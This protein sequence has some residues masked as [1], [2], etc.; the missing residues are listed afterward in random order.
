MPSPGTTQPLLGENVNLSFT[1][2]NTDPTDVGYSPY[3]VV[4]VDTSGV[5]GATTA[6]LDGLTAPT[7]TGAGLNL[8]PVGSPVTL[9]AGQTTF[10]NPF[11]GLTESVPAGFGKNDT[12]YVYQLPFGSF[13][14]NQ[15]TAVTIT[16]GVS[17]LADVN[18][19]L[20]LS[21]VGGYRSSQPNSI[22][23]VTPPP[24]VATNITPQLYR[25]KKV[26]QGPEDET[27][28]GPNFVRRYRLELDVADGQ[29]LTNLR[30]IDDLPPSH[31]IVGANTTVVAGQ[32]NMAA[33]R[34]LS[35]GVQG[36]NI[37][38]SSNLT[39]TAVSSAPDGTLN[40]NFG[41]HLG[42]AGVDA[43]FEYNFYVPR[44]QANPPGGA[45][46]PQGVDK[47]L[48]TNTV[49]STANWTPTDTRDPA[50]AVTP[51]ISG[52][53]F[54]HVLEQQS[55][56]VQKGV[57]LFDLTTGTVLNGQAVQPG[58]TL[59]RYT[60]DF[61]VSDY[62]A[63]QNITLEDLLS[64][65][66]R[67]YLANLPAGLGGTAALPT[68]AVNNAF[69]ANAA[70]NVGTRTNTTGAFTANGVIEY[71]GRFTTGNTL[72]DPS[73]GVHGYAATGP[74]SGIFTNLGQTPDTNV[75][76]GGATYLK[77]DISAELRQRLGAN[78]GR[79]IGGE[80]NNDGTGPDN[81][82]FAGPRLGP[83]TGQIIFYALVSEEFSDAFP[84]GNPSVDQGDILQNSVPEIF[85]EQ[86]TAATINAVTPTRNP[87][88]AISTDDSG[89]SFSVPYGVSEKQVYAIN[90]QTVPAA[91]PTD[92]PLEIQ[93]GDRVTFKLTYTL[94][95][96]SFEQLSLVDIPPLP[97]MPVGAQE[98]YRFESSGATFNPY[99]VSIAP[100]DTFFSTIN[101][102]ATPVQAATIAALG[103]GTYSPTG[104]ASG[105]GAFT[106]APT[107]IDG[108][109]LVNGDR[110][111]VKNQ[112]DSRQNGVYVVLNA[113]TGAW[114]RA[115]DFDAVTEVQN[116]RIFQVQFGA[117]NT[118]NAFVPNNREF[119]SFN[120]GSA[121]LSGI[122][123]QSFVT[124]DPLQNEI[125]FNFGNLSDT[126]VRRSTTISLLLT[127]PMGTDPFVADLFLT[128]QL[129][130]LEASTNQGTTT[131]EDLRMIELVRP[132]V[133]IQ[134]GAVAGRNIGLTTSD[135]VFQFAPA[136]NPTGTVT[137][138]G[139]PLSPTN[140]IFS[141]GHASAI[142]G[143]NI[144]PSNISLDAS[145]AVRYAL[146]VNN[147]GAGDAYDVV[148]EDQIQ[149]GLVIPPTFNDLNLRVFRGDGSA[150]T[151]RT[152]VNGVVRAA[153]NGAFPPAMGVV[154]TT[155]SGGRFT[156]VDR[157]FSGIQLNLGD[158][159]LIKNQ[160]N[161][162]E[163]GIYSVT[164]VDLA[165]QK[166]VLTRSVDF[167]ESSEL[168]A[169]Y[170]VGVLGGANHDNTLYTFPATPGAVLNSTNVNW[171][172]GGDFDYFYQYNPN[173]T[174][175]FG[176]EQGGF[177]LFFRD[178]YTAGNV[179]GAAADFGSGALSSA[180]NNGLPITNGSNSL[181]VLYDTTVAP[182]SNTRPVHTGQT[183]VNTAFV[184]NFSNQ[185]GG[186]DF[187]DPT[188]VADSTDPSDTATVEILR[189]TLDKV[190][191]SS[192]VVNS[193][194]SNTQVV[195]G[196]IV[197]YTLT[198]TIPEG[199]TRNTVLLD[200]LDSGLAFV[201]VTSVT[202]SGSLTFTGGGLPTVGTNPANTTITNNGNNVSF[203]LGT[204]NN[205]NSDNTTAETITIV[206][207][208]VVLNVAGNQAGTQL[209][210]SV[211][212]TADRTNSP[213]TT[214]TS[215]NVNQTNPTQNVTVIEPRIVTAKQVSKDGTNFTVGTFDLDREDTL[216]YR[217]VLGNNTLPL[218]PSVRVATT[219]NIGTGYV[220]NIEGYSRQITGG[221][222]SIDG[223]TLQLQ[224]RVLVKNQSNAAQNG[225]YVYTAPGV[226]TSAPEADIAAEYVPN[227][228]LRVALGT[229]N[230]GRIFRQNNTVTTLSTDPIAYTEISPT[231]TDAVDAYDVTVF[232]PL[233]TSSRQAYV[234][235]SFTAL[236]NGT[237]DISSLFELVQPGGPNT[238][239]VLRT[240]DGSSFDLLVG[241]F[242]QITL[243]GTVSPSINP[244]ESLANSATVRWT[245]LNDAIPSPAAGLEPQAGVP[246]VQSIHNPNSTE[247]SGTPN[248]DGSGNVN[249]YASTG[250]VAPQAA[251]PILTKLVVG[252]SE[253]HTIQNRSLVKFGNNAAVDGN[254]T[255]TSGTGTVTPAPFFL[256]VDGNETFRG[257]YTFPTPVN[258]RG[259]TTLGVSLRADVG[260]TADNIVLTLSDVDG[261][262]ASYTF[263][264]DGASLPP[265]SLSFSTLFANLLAPTITSNGA[266]S[267]L[268]ITRIANVSI[269]GDG[270]TAVFRMDIRDITALRTLVA[271]GEIVRYRLIF[272][273][274]E[275]QL[276]DLMLRDLLPAGMQ[277]L[278]DGTA[279]V[280]FVTNGAGMTSS[281]LAGAGLLFAGD[282]DNINQI[283]LSVASGNGLILPDGAISTSF[284]INDDA[285]GNGTDVIFK[286]GNILNIENDFDSEYIVVEFNAQVLNVAT[287]QSGV[288]L[289]NQFEAFLNGSTTPLQLGSSSGGDIPGPSAVTDRNRIVVV[290]PQINNL[291][292]QIN[293][294][295]PTDAGDPIS[296]EIR[297]SNNVAHP[298]VAAPRVRASTTGNIAPVS[299]TAN[300]LI[301]PAT[302]GVLT[303]D[304]VA[305]R[306]QDRVLVRAQSTG[307]Q[308]G[309]Y[310]VTELN[311]QTGRAT[312][313]RASD[314]DASSE[315]VFGARVQ[316]LEGSNAGRIYGI[317]TTGTITPGSSNIAFEQLAANPEVRVATVTA[318]GGTFN[319]GTNTYT[320]ANRT[321]DGVTLNNGDRVLVKNQAAGEAQ[322]H[323]VFVVT[324]ASGSTVNLVRA[325]DFDQSAEFTVG[326]QISVLEGAVNA[327]RVFGMYS[328]VNT[329]NTDNIL[330]RTV[331]QVAAFNLVLTDPLPTDVLFQSITIFTPENPAGITLTASGSFTG[332][333]VTLPAVG[334]TGTITITL[335]RLD[336]EEDITGAVK[337]VRILVNGVV[338]DL[339]AGGQFLLNKTNLTYTGL[340]GG[341][342]LGNPTGSNILGAAG[343]TTGERTGQD[344][345]LPNDNTPPTFSPTLNN[346]SVG[347]VL[348]TP[349][350]TPSI[351]KRFQGGSLTEDDTSFSSTT[352]SNVAIGE[353]IVYDLRVTLPEGQINNLAIQDLL[354]PGLRL[355][356]T[357]NG[358]LGYELITAASL[359]N[360]QLTADFNGTLNL[361][362]T[363]TASGGTLGNDGVD[364]VLTF[365]NTTVNTALTTD[366]SFLIRVRVIA[367]NVGSN[368]RGTL[369]TNVATLSYTDP[370]TNTTATVFDTTNTDGDATPF[371]PTVIIVEPQLQ[372][373]KTVLGGDTT[374]DAGLPSAATFEL[375]IRHTGVSNGPAFDLQI[376][377]LIPTGLS[378]VAGSAIIFS[379]PAY[380]N[381]AIVNNGPSLSAT[382]D[383]LRVGDVI[384][385]RYEAFIVGPPNAN[386]PAPGGT[387]TN[388][389][390]TNY[391][392]APGNNP[393]ERDEAQISDTETLTVHT[394]TISGRIYSDR[395]N[396]GLFDGTDV[397]I[398]GQNIRVRLTGTDHLG[399]AVD[400]EITT[401]TG[402]YS[403]TGLRPG[404]YSVT[405]LDQPVGF[406]DGRDTPGT[407]SPGT[408][409]GGTGTAATDNRGTPSTPT[410]D[411]EA[412]NSITIGL[413]QNKDGIEYNF[414]EVQPAELGN[415]VWEDLNGN[416]R[417]DAGEPGISGISVQ[418]N[419]TDDT[420]A[421]V[422]ESTTTNGTGNYLFTNLR[423]GSYS[424]TFGNSNG[425]K[426]Y[427]RTVAN[428]AVANDTNDSDAN[429]TTGITGSYTLIAGQSD[430]TVDAGLY[431]PITLGNRVFFDIDADGKQD[432][433]EPGIANVDIQ[434]VWLG[435]DGVFGGGDDKTFTTQTDALGIWT[436]AGLPPGSFKVTA[437]PPLN[438]GYTVLTDSFDNGILSP[439]N[440][441]TPSTT[442]GVNRDDIDFGYR[443][444]AKLGDFVW[445]DRDADGVQDVGEPGLPGVTVRLTFLGS[446]GVLGGGDDA[447]FETITDATGK[448]QF[449]N[450]PA[451]KFQV[452]VL[453]NTLPD[454][455]VQTFD[456]NGGLDNLATRQL[457][458]G[459][460]ATDVDFG[461]V[462]KGSIGD[463]VWYD[464][465]GDGVQDLTA[466][467]TERGI[468]GVTVT[469]TWGGQDG[470]LSTTAD[471]LIYTTTT[472]ADGKYLFSGLFAGDFL[473]ATA[474]NYRVTV[475]QP[476]SFP[477]RTFDADG[478]GTANVSSLRLPA[479]TA[480][481]NQDFGYRGTASLGDFV[482]EDTNGNGKFDSG[483]LGV[484]GVTVELY[485]DANN[486]GQV[487]G[488]ELAAPIRSTVT[489]ANGKYAFPDLAAG[490]YRV[491]FVRPV[492]T[493]FTVPNSTVPG[494]NDTND[495]DASNLPASQGLTQV[496]ALANGGSDDTVDAG[497]VRLVN[498]GDTVW[499]DVNKNGVQNVG[500][501]GI[502]NVRINLAYA[503]PDGV[504]GTGDDNLTLAFTDTDSEGKYFF[505]LLFPGV[506]KVSVDTSTGD[507][508]T[509]GLTQQTYD[510]DGIV[511]TPNSDTKLV[512]SG[513]NDFAFDFGYVGTRKLGDRV[514]VDQND[515][516]IQDPNE[517]GISGAKVTAQ[518]A[519]ADGLFNTADDV[520]QTQI[521]GANGIYTFTDIPSGKYRVSVDPTT[522]PNG[523]TIP[524]YDLDDTPDST[525]DVTLNPEFD[526]DDVDF[527]YRGTLSL[528]DRVWFDHDGD[529]VQD[530]GEPGVVGAKVNLIWA[531]QDG[532]L[533][534]TADNLVISTITGANGIY[535]FTNLP[536]GKFKVSVD[537]STLPPN[538]TV[539]TYD[540]D[541]GTTAPDQI[542]TIDNLT[543]NRV[544]VDFGYKGTLSLGD[545]IWHDQDGDGLQDGGEQGFV[546]VTVTLV[547]AGQDNDFATTADNLV[548]TTTTGAN[549]LYGFSALPQGAY[550]VTVGAGLPTNIVATYDLDNG[551]TN[552][553]GEAVL[554]GAGKL[555]VSRT[556]VDFGYRGNV[557]IGNEVWFDIDGDGVFDGDEIGIG[558]VTV[559]VRYF[560][561]NG[562]EG[563]GDDMLFSAVTVDGTGFWQIANLPEGKYRA[564]VD[565]TTLPTGF[566]QQTYDL[567]LGT[568]GL[569]NTAVFTVT[570]TGRQD[571]DFGYRG[572]A[573]L[574]DLVWED[575]V[576]E[577]SATTVNNDPRSAN[578]KFDTGEKVLQGV[579]VSL[580]WAGRDGVFGN[581]DDFTRT[582]TTD[583]NGI[584]QFLNLPAGQFEVT[585]KAPTGYVF[586][587]QNAAADN[588]DSDADPVTGKTAPI[589]LLTGES[590]QTVDA[591]VFQPFLI[592]EAVPVCFFDTP[593]ISYTVTPVGVANPQEVDISFFKNDGS[594]EFVS[595]FTNPTFSGGKFTG[596]VLYPGAKLDGN[597][598]PIDW[599]GWDLVGGRWVQVNDGLRPN[600]RMSFGI[601]PNASLIVS[602]PDPSQFC[603]S[604]PTVSIG[605]LIFADLN[606]NGVFDPGA[607]ETG[608]DGVVVELWNP[609]ADGKIGGGDDTLVDADTIA[610]GIQGS[611]VT[612]NGGAYLFNRIISGQYYV[613]IPESN[614]QPG[615]ALVGLVSSYQFGSDSTTD[616]NADENG[617]DA[618]NPAAV[619]IN[620]SVFDAQ[621]TLQPTGEPQFG[622]GTF[623]ADISTNLTFDFGFVEPVTV[624][625]YAFIDS[626]G[627][628]VQDAGDLPLA[629]VVVELIDINGNVLQTATTG[630]DG[631][632]SFETAPGAYSIR[633]TPPSGYRATVAN[634]GANDAN[635]S[636]IDVNTLTTAQF[637]LLA[638]T[639]DLTRDAGFYIPISLGDRVWYD[640]NND[641]LQNNGEPGIP[642]AKVT[643]TWLGVDGVLGGGDD[644][645]YNP[646][647]TD[648]NGNWTL[649]SLPPGNF[650]VQVT[651]LPEGV[652]PTYDLDGVGTPSVTGVTTTSGVDRTDVDF[653][654][655][656][657]GSLGD[658]IFLD[659]NKNGVYD[660]GEGLNNVTVTVAGDLNGDGIVG[661]GETLTTTTGSDGFYQFT[662]L[663]VTAAGVDY[664]VTVNKA[665]LPQ[666]FNGS[667]VINSVD[668]DTASPGDSTSKVTLTAAVPN[669][670]DQ[671]FGYIADGALG[672]TIFVDVNNN[673]AYDA[674]EGVSGVTV[675][676]TADFDLDGTPTT[677]T[678]VTGAD[679]KYLFET[680][681]V[682]DKNG[683]FLPYTVN[684][685]TNTLPA[686]LTN[687]VDPDG[688]NNSKSVT[689]LG[690]GVPTPEVELAQ[691]FGYRGPG[692]I[693]DRIFVDLNGD[694]VFTPGEGLFGVT[695]RLTAD[696]TGDGIPE[697][698]TTTTGADGAYLFSGLPIFR[699]DGTT[700]I[701][702]TVEVLTNT[703]PTGLT[704]SVDPDGG[705]NSTSQLT[706]VANA[707]NL[708]QDFGYVGTAKLGD[709]VWLDS[710]GDGAQG[711]LNLEPGLPGSKLTLTWAGADGQ[712]GTID[713]AFTVL[714]TDQFGNY[715]FE[716]LALGN[717]SV[718]VDPAS[719]PGNLTP[720]Y[721][722]DGVGTANVATRALIL[723]EVAT[724]VDFGYVGNASLGDRVWIDQNRD[725]IQDPTEPGVPGAIVEVRWAGVDGIIDTSDDVLYSTTTGPNGAY[726][727]PGLPVFGADDVYRVSVTGL[728]IV[729]LIPVYDLD[730]GIATPDQTTLATVASS[731]ALQNRR[732]VDFGYDGEGVL[733]G[734]VYRDDNNNGVQDPGEPGIAGVTLT[735]FGVDPFGNPILN[736]VTGQPY[737]TT[738]DANG[739]YGFQTAIPGVYRIVETQ[740]GAY[741]DG[742]DSAGNLGGN[743]GN[744]VI[745][746]INVPAN[747]T[748]V[749]YNFGEIGTF[750]S[751]TVFYDAARDG[752]F[753][754][755][756][757]GLGGVI[758]ELR[759]ASNNLV[760]T[761]T[762]AADGTYRFDNLPAG[763]Y[764]ITEIQPQGYGSST[765]NTLN[766]TVPLAGLTN[767]NFGETLSTI[768]GNVFH[769]AN[770]D[771]I[772]NA[773]EVGIA[774]VVVTLT[775]TDL[776]GNPVNRTTFT[777]ANGNYRFVELLAS[778]DAG[779]TISEFLPTGYLDGKDQVGSFGGNVG[780]TGPV[781]TI[782]AIPTPSGSDGFN[783][784][785]GEIASPLRTVSGTVF[786]DVA[787]NGILE[788]GDQG[789]SG[790]LVTLYD[791]KNN[792]VGTT[793]TDANG[794]YAFT[795]LPPGKYTIVESQPNAYGSSS[796]NLLAVDLTAGN[797]T[798]QNF[799]ETT[800]D[801]AGTVYFD[802]NQDGQL[803]AGETGI[804]GVTVTLTGTDVNGNP[805]TQST[806]TDAN[807]NYRFTGLLA[808]NYTVTETQ[809]AIYADG[810]E[811]LGSLGGITDANDVIRAIPLGAGISATAYNF[812]EIG[813]PVSGTVFYDVNRNGE[814]DGGETPIGGV[815]IQL[816][817]SNGQVVATT[818]T[819]GFGNYQFSNVPP[820]QYTI[821]EIQPAGYGDPLV[822]SFAPNSRPITVANTPITGQNFG[823]TLSTI[824]GYVY[825]D[826]N[827]NNVRD[828][829]EPGIGGVVM[830]LDSAGNDGVFGTSDDVLEVAFTTTGTNG[831]YSFTKLPQ[832]VYRVVEV[833]QPGLY[834]DGAETAGAAGGDISTNDQISAI[835]L[836]AG[837]DQPDYNFGE[838]LVTVQGTG[839]ITGT[840]YLDT[841]N[842]GVQDPGE[843]GL[844]G[845]EVSVTNGQSTFVTLTDANGNYSFTNLIP[846]DYTVTETQP[847]KYLTGLENSG[848]TSSA[849]VPANGQA[850]VNFGELPGTITGVVYFDADQSG[851]LTA[852]DKVLPG[853]LVSLV[854][855]EGFPV[856]DRLTGKPL[857]AVTGADG[858]YTFTGLAAGTYRVLETQP[859]QYNQGATNPGDFGSLFDVDA[860]TVELPAGGLS[861][862]NNFGEIGAS[863]SGVV[864]FDANA[865]GDRQP[866]E[867]NVLAGVTITLLDGQ[868]NPIATTTTAADGSY[869]FEN[870]P[871]G[872]YFVVQTQPSTH[873]SSPSGLFAPNLRPVTL[874]T[875]DVVNQNFAETLGSI[876][877]VVYND[878]NNNGIQ[879]VGEP[880]IA[881]VLLT[882]TGT[883][884]NGN[885][886]SVTTTTDANGKYLFSELLTG[887][888]SVTETQPAQYNDGLD[889]IGSI[890][891]VVANDLQSQIQLGAGIQATGYNFGEIGADISGKVY[892]D[893]N[894][895]GTIDGR[896]IAFAGVTIQLLDANGKLIATTKTAA[897]GTYLFEHLPA[898]KYTIV[899]LQ[900]NGYGS[901]TPNTLPVTLPLTGLTNQN[902]G[903]TLS[904][905]GGV[906]FLDDNNNGVRD[907]NEIG[908]PN[909]TI[910]LTGTDVNNL[911]IDRTVLTGPDG[912]YRF[913]DLVQGSYTLTETQPV[914][915]GDGQDI[916]G[917]FGGT[918][919]NDVI[920]K[921]P[922][923]AGKI[924]VGYDFGEL[925]GEVRGTV[926]VDADRD[927]V[928]DPGE[929]R[930]PGEIVSLVDS[931]GNVYATTT[932]DANGN[933]AFIGIPP[934]NYRV[935]QTQPNGY[936]SS[937]SNDVPVS[938]PPS[939][940]PVIV[941]FGET[942]GSLSGYVYRDFA[943][944]GLRQPDQGETGIG[945]VRITLTGTDVR[946][947]LINREIFTDSAGRYDFTGLLQG[948][949]VISESKPNGFFYDGLDTIGSQGGST[950]NDR[951]ELFLGAGVDGIENNFGENP[952]ADPFGYV[953]TD[954]NRNGVRDPGEPGIAGVPIRIEG[955]AFAGTPLARPLQDSDLPGGSRT[956]FTNAAGRYEYPIIPPGVYTIIQVLQPV[957]YL[958]GVEENADPNEP[959]T[960]IVGNDRFD[961]IVLDPFPIRGPFNFGELL[962]QN[963]NE[964]G[965]QSFLAST[966]S[967]MTPGTSV[968]PVFPS[969]PSFQVTTGTP[970]Q[971][972][973]VVT[974]SGTGGS[975]VVR[976]FDFATG[977][978]MLRFE[979]FESTFTGGVRTAT[980][981]INQDGIA[982][983]IVVPGFGGGPIVR[984]F[985]GVDG[986]VIREFFAYDPNFRDGL[987][988]A[989]GDVTGDGVVDIVTSPGQG[990]GPHIQVW[991]GVTGQSVRSFFAY[992]SSFRGGVHVAV[993]DTDGDGFADIITGAGFGGG[994]HVRVFSGRTGDELQSFM[995]Y[996][997]NV[998]GGA[999]VAAGDV[1000]GDGRAEIITGAGVG[1001]GPNVKVFR[1002]SDLMVLS[1003][1004][1005]A[1006]DP[1007]FFGGVRVST[1008]DIDGD[1009]RA[1010]IVSGTGDGSTL[1011]TIR[1012]LLD[1013]TDLETFAPFDLSESGGVFVG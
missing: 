730:S 776:L 448:Y 453:T 898:G 677:I 841:N 956:I 949:Y 908:V 149:P 382:A 476:A 104:G 868:G 364:F 106:G 25:L 20:N 519:G 918:L 307:T 703:I 684:V 926:Y 477:I 578:G 844:I 745:D 622:P 428:S 998:R 600:I 109:A 747:A 181:L 940:I 610:P 301:I 186:L 605:N 467:A 325:T 365:G 588:L 50:T 172:A 814:I 845:V 257:N 815:T 576:A 715:L 449:T 847:S 728:P 178:S 737:T 278:N 862:N 527:G 983:I 656:G 651:N 43:V 336:A 349:L 224:D 160:A 984:V 829:G 69:L 503:G 362:P 648:A 39:G 542:V 917:S 119:L 1010:E 692:S 931:Q 22:V 197:T 273:A 714:V 505:N 351:D 56:A 733:G 317:R 679:G 817:D 863:I 81:D 545:R 40:Y 133:S 184:R 91:G 209:N 837:V 322:N 955:I 534:T 825:V 138:S 563:D 971:P 121:T 497:I 722:L 374:R 1008:Q 5:D 139:N 332:G 256:R 681:P 321:I 482:W 954:L 479:N 957:G 897:D 655:R 218:D 788:L 521:T 713:D 210:N 318:V 634:V 250:S 154:Y 233:P 171:V 32:P 529:G 346:Y 390:T 772:R 540:L 756:D 24:A 502:A 894:R 499:Y 198:L 175:Q 644:I 580:R 809:P 979:A 370:N 44:D 880:G 219:A 227:Q 120:S 787:K 466:S 590:N 95:I 491:R 547:Y 35:P 548:L 589:T 997:P 272:Q 514:W 116:T 80:I 424:V 10:V 326:R 7:V 243:T 73:V 485:W 217:I 662:N 356:T 989:V 786:V 115:T 630:A 559:N 214:S 704:N 41:T 406:L 1:F 123:F 34:Y 49:S 876:A 490:N 348:V 793:T 377:D 225:I 943:I 440:P 379:A 843:V 16:T 159:V 799:G 911:P 432:S 839:A 1013:N 826:T 430:L 720:T 478:L 282:Q 226:F 530:S 769:D 107:T 936:S 767:Q 525:T 887:T 682:R 297:F 567:D 811:S 706:L 458:S 725:G 19:P 827:V 92:P 744:D 498:I 435:P 343:T 973:F 89:A 934:G 950:T 549:G 493:E 199:Q 641:G 858:S 417:F 462:G 442:S 230:G 231:Y 411:G 70:T 386:A 574:G 196:E 869:S 700:P 710:N 587:P 208:A 657:T 707:N 623:Q 948:N 240:R 388:T 439:T 487:D 99:S 946:G 469:L 671:D 74:T 599:P 153:S 866:T 658:R 79:L 766:V 229:A 702:Y 385:I 638:G 909:V 30:V 311:T 357:F 860:I 328:T 701:T 920:S 127:L 162:Q 308:N 637:T 420:G 855:V 611:V 964:V 452:E 380:S 418:I 183:I 285:Y 585:F 17:K 303:I 360:G 591:G 665:D 292:K 751:G 313:T 754:T 616:Q 445:H 494:A 789:L 279:R 323:G 170:R 666:R 136:T 327:G 980:G 100:D 859:N 760:A 239:Q 262:T 187:T 413:E 517:P 338:R 277:F 454:E 384:R 294:T 891:G 163:N 353:S 568:N 823:N 216:Y 624:G 633:F 93:A 508:D 736:P 663:R 101:A 723:G 61:Q 64:D 901:S 511:V 732:D 461:Y 177:R 468:P 415:L 450:L 718:T 244:A 252:S 933:Y 447:V 683:S 783:Y 779:Y 659:L 721:D 914:T 211:Q 263:A 560:G 838:V 631:K 254:F 650:K 996:D 90:S 951:H 215:Y 592:I 649:G 394:N 512:P 935:V 129:R 544:D 532:D 404:V 892:V 245:S 412:I 606:G 28:T 985:S 818:T 111:L 222:T 750:I 15:S 213:G 883:D 632:Y 603:I 148:V 928:L 617:I 269:G 298:T 986:T 165:T 474:P 427:D 944:N 191:T 821:V 425:S 237:T 554:A 164:S 204:I 912:S 393:D 743:T 994:P 31:Q 774:G 419:G 110:V 1009:G 595:T 853:V 194:N 437:T 1005:F 202:S 258:L 780:Q 781:D 828:V 619:G 824:S 865:D 795:A 923:P 1001:G 270:G 963:I 849:T 738:T 792:I 395:N 1000:D 988:V 173:V 290:E 108:R 907:A 584:Y 141:P 54:Q 748:G 137:R 899:E 52:S 905:I 947:N 85:G 463:T 712:L 53:T 259:Y 9:I 668:P 275:G 925:R 473:D 88:A 969:T 537:A 709:R 513:K 773:G 805:V 1004:Y 113:A 144:N 937:T 910:R 565:T 188:Y 654:Y 573:K 334:T 500:E 640:T 12:I 678:T 741:N 642:N 501:P 182:V 669:R 626:N 76:T 691:D 246:I 361:T 991:D 58:R 583:S 151:T 913:D 810:Q 643:V 822:G 922:V 71:Q 398:T 797:K 672:D 84:S 708:D 570:G 389:A 504:F 851:T 29:T 125:R 688:G 794:N 302:G 402:L 992:D 426:T 798:G 36:G 854:D 315:L 378:M 790:V 1007:R 871:P 816:V 966:P 158:R 135:N 759:D 661:A 300:T 522:L 265:G 264:I 276:N 850:V 981:D 686:G 396:N 778:N 126:G 87:G 804:A 132:N 316:V 873:A 451:G 903:E 27:A 927:G 189:P 251:T 693:G 653:G 180:S 695:V 597:G 496:V 486:N 690:N 267:I 836:A 968:M 414:G 1012:R 612:A 329:L 1003:S 506:Y 155:T 62:F 782:V 410:R 924:G 958:D 421:S 675:S 146:V 283:D 867:T 742:I 629:S 857:T 808:G 179:G 995:A 105:N 993:G 582:V 832:G 893:Y 904:S 464:A 987:F 536:T 664:T 13:N 102:I 2:T 835:P 608:I 293:G 147:Q 281:T 341:G 103:S 287:N 777:D 965:K 274:P 930:L 46:I 305:L 42:V 518:W 528:G 558:G 594:N 771:G 423:P 667:L 830:Q 337:N 796:P 564:T 507:M 602:Y 55:I 142:G 646:V 271:P 711:P 122:S 320:G 694:G 330:W 18:T 37:F 571:V 775:G 819:D 864:F 761:T 471:N 26:Y 98:Q 431:L 699:P 807:G 97:V 352:G 551:T 636:D 990:G 176:L 459:E 367:T 546:G 705:N 812:G 399:N 621:A 952:P 407:S 625:D 852:G 247:R 366:N 820:G 842:N 572:T 369:L 65:G 86:I 652:V 890:G 33:Y 895:N 422:S 3:I 128:N 75:N 368:V 685:I 289:S 785:F 331:D 902:F 833:N 856:L 802:A 758:I 359:S 896:D 228:F 613:R 392:T 872:E 168:Q 145:D 834:Q 764:T 335:D 509:F 405:Q 480:N 900:P 593:Y 8:S 717:Y 557:T 238:R 698:V 134:K 309:V 339:A 212:L 169:G 492:G 457:A 333:S 260:S 552:P 4:A 740:P 628:G 687:T 539:A 945:G 762:T 324:N 261:T 201:D 939:N 363:L 345:T 674:G 673:G 770:N 523:I 38:N 753:N 609:G 409:F 472:D 443:G 446:D 680:L 355:D 401:N 266:D 166:V 72:S 757:S 381:A 670:P 429:P 541:S 932:T 526:R 306:L 77:F 235:T 242:V 223:V 253:D 68:L 489:D 441:V 813:V 533:T 344:V 295:A 190:F 999:F 495:S 627:N 861:A 387:I 14:P 481:L 408:P 647:T 746:G 962:P 524:T 11:T 763:N 124:T 553:N 929:Q 889:T 268:D 919:G 535:N 516:G 577:A 974:S 358:G 846:G 639:D 455:F 438:S 878:F 531:G 465:D 94:P 200:T 51:A 234:A 784:N 131:E 961:N 112:A 596:K 882:L 174:P 83:T 635:D 729:G 586:S 460:T 319:S 1011:V 436:V 150:L 550:K 203:N 310:V 286:F 555:T 972:A 938:V 978:E 752:V 161:A 915:Y 21:V 280:A 1006:F 734:T 403:F 185:S 483:E 57:T 921:I 562:I 221:P 697:V 444:T 383:E 874:G 953:Y 726:L 152:D 618:V 470:D 456:L 340:P 312:L 416:G 724:D 970:L 400:R 391:D 884:I 1002:G 347:A 620:G 716:R 66:Q 942:T 60:I 870:L 976:V 831:F 23:P 47:T 941:N 614:F 543:A 117:V 888:Y 375:V 350:V 206:Y 205:S 397:L 484:A 719:I 975:P 615:G 143:L 114:Q 488:G 967:E 561:A 848:N 195:V 96:T 575:F 977:G 248:D 207:R 299:S 284:T 249:D 881:G 875:A 475:A 676:L 342:T 604:E 916:V 157:T 220:T 566:N 877:G 354:P 82:P 906:V 372:I 130:I 791:S 696:L 607:G 6:P 241:Q 581:G 645:V 982:D 727:F 601:N 800:S 598:N 569:G 304:G 314:F 193:T 236:L 67:L 840:V 538:L 765:P 288:D 376:A 749:A 959:A 63:L 433:G 520:T 739:N 45:V 291:S 735:L 78:A 755:G 886:V 48:G 434:V 373:E 731:G 885:P 510:R 192:S 515:D 255:S 806:T 801:L 556:D 156:N 118:G 232:D 140:A 879:D 371:D 660:A 579:E 768:S 167:N 803:S 689:T 59:A 960:V 296:Y